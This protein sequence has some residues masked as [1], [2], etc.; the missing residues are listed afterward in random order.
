MVCSCRG[1]TTAALPLG[2]TAGTELLSP[3]VSTK[4]NIGS[5]PFTEALAGTRG[6]LLCLLGR[7]AVLARK[8]FAPL[9]LR[10]KAVALVAYLSLAGTEISRR[11]VAR[12]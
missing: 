12:R 6:S 7:P 8:Q 9:R 11:E 4:G 5:P 10:P 3:M 1:R 2:E